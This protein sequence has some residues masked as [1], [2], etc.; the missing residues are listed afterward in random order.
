MP[1][2]GKFTRRTL[3]EDIRDILR[4]Y[5]CDAQIFK[6][7]IQNGED[8]GASKITFLYDENTYTEQNNFSIAGLKDYQ[9]PSLYAYN[10]AKF[11]EKDWEGISSLG[12]SCKEK[13][14]L[15]V[16]KFGLGFKS[17]FHLSDFPMV[18]SGT[19]FMFL[20]P[21]VCTL[22][23][24]V[25]EFDFQNNEDRLI[26]QNHSDFELFKRLFQIKENGVSGT[27]FRFPLRQK[28]SDLSEFCYNNG[29]LNE[30]IKSLKENGYLNLLFL[31]CVKHIELCRISKGSNE[32]VVEYSIALT[33]D[34]IKKYGNSKMQFIDKI[35]K[36]LQS[37]SYSE[38]T[39]DYEVNIIEKEIN[40]PEVNYCYFVSEYYSGASSD[41][42]N[43]QSLNLLPLVTVAYPKNDQY[44]D[45]VGGHIFCVLPLPMWQKGIT[46]LPV[47]VNGF[48]ALSEDRR[49]LKWPTDPKN[50]NKDQQVLWNNFLITKL[51]PHAYSNLM[52]YLTQMRLSSDIV[53]D[54]WPEKDDVDK[55]WQ[56]LLNPFFEKVSQLKCFYCS[57]CKEW[58]Y[59]S[60][61]YILR[62][63]L[64]SSEEQNLCIRGFFEMCSEK[65]SIVPNHVQSYF[66]SLKL[67]SKSL[68]QTTLKKNLNFYKSCKS[69]DMMHILEFILTDISDAEK[70][71]AIPLLPMHDGTLGSINYKSG[72]NSSIFIATDN[73]PLEIFPSHQNFF[74]QKLLKEN[75]TLMKIFQSVAKTGKFNITVVDSSQQALDVIKAYCEK[76]KFSFKKVIMNDFYHNWYKS[77]WAY[78]KKYRLSLTN[79]E[80]IPVVL[81]KQQM[82][83]SLNVLTQK[84]TNVI[85][86]SFEKSLLTPAMK[87]FLNKCH[88]PILYAND[89]DQI[90][91][92]ELCSNNFIM[93]P[94]NQG[95]LISLMNHHLQ[96]KIDVLNCISDAPIEIRKV[97]RAGMEKLLENL[98]LLSES[99]KTFVKKLKVFE[100]LHPPGEFVCLDQSS[101]IV[102]KRHFLPLMSC[103]GNFIDSTS[104]SCTI[105]NA[106][107]LT[108]LSFNDVVFFLTKYFQR[109]SL[110][111]QRHLNEFLLVCLEKFEP[112]IDAL[113]LLKNQI[114]IESDGKLLK[115]SSLFEKT[116]ELEKMFFGEISRFPDDRY[117]T[118][119]LKKLGLKLKS[120]L[121]S[122]DLA[123][124]ISFI[125]K[126]KFKEEDFSKLINKIKIILLAK[127]FSMSNYLHLKWIPIKQKCLGSYPLSLQWFG[128]G[129]CL[130]EPSNVYL[131]SHECLIG[132]VA[133]IIHPSLS[134]IYSKKFSNINPSLN[135]IMKHL[136]NIEINYNDEEK[137]LYKQNIQI[138]YN[139]LLRFN[140]DDVVDYFKKHQMK[141]WSGSYFIGVNKVLFK[142]MSLNYDVSP[143]YNQ[144]KTVIS[145]VIEKYILS[146]DSFPKNE[147]DVYLNVL[148]Q[149]KEKHDT[150]DKDTSF[151]LDLS[152]KLVKYIASNYSSLPKNSQVFVPIQSR[153]LCLNLLS[154]CYYKSSDTADSNT[155]YNLLHEL[156]SEDDAKMLN[157]RNLVSVIISPSTFSCFQSWGQQ[158]PLTTKLNRVLKLYND[159]FAI[160]KEF[161][162]NADDAGAKV[163]KFLYDKRQNKELKNNLIDSGMKHW[164]GP[165]LWIYNS[166]E[167]TE[168][169]FV[170]ITKLNAGTKEFDTSKVG[171]F[172]L[173][174]NSVYHL[175]DVPSILSG[176]TLVVFDPHTEYLGRAIHD[177]REPGIKMT[178]EG[179]SN[180]IQ[181]SN[182]FKVFHGIFDC[183]LD[184]DSEDVQTFKGTLFRI[185]LRSSETAPLSKISQ[186]VYSENEMK[187]LYQKIEER[188]KHLLLFTENVSEF[189]LFE[190]SDD[191]NKVL[192]ISTV[193][194][195]IE[196]IH[197]HGE[198]NEISVMKVCTHMLQNNLNFKNIDIQLKVLID[199]VVKNKT[200]RN[201]YLI[202][203]C[204]GGENSYAYAKKNKGQ[205]SCGS[206]AIEISDLQGNKF[207]ENADGDL[208]CFLPL[209]IK[210]GLPVHVNGFFTLSS[211]RKHLLITTHD[212]KSYG[213]KDWNNILA[214]D[215]S[216]AYINLLL[217]LKRLNSNY[218]L[219][220]WAKIIP[221]GVTYSARNIS[222][223][224]LTK[225]FGKKLVENQL[226]LFPT[227]I[228]N[229]WISWKHLRF[230]SNEIHSSIR[231]EV[232]AFMNWYYSMMKPRL[233]VVDTPE[234]VVNLLL[235]CGIS[236]ESNKITVK[237]FISLFLDCLGS[238]LLDFNLRNKITIYFI[239]NN[240]DCLYNYRCLPTKPNE[241]L[242]MSSECVA[243]DSKAASLFFLYDEVFVLDQF[244]PFLSKFKD[245][246]SYNL[247]WPMILLCARSISRMSDFEGI[248][249]RSKMLIKLMESTETNECPKYIKND[250]FKT[251][252]L[253]SYEKP[254]W[255]PFNIHYGECN[256]VEAPCNS[257]GKDCLYLASVTKPI[258]KFH[259]KKSLFNFLGLNKIPSFE[260]VKQQLID[261]NSKSNI[262][263][264]RLQTI[265]NDIYN[266]LHSHAT[267]SQ[268]KELNELC[269]VY[270]ENSYL[271]L[272]SLTFI[273]FPLDI[274]PYIFKLSKSISGNEVQKSLMIKLGVK[275]KPEL[276][277]YLN[278]L[279]RINEDYKFDS[280][281]DQLLKAINQFIIP[282]LLPYK[283]S[284]ISEKLYLPDTNGKLIT[285]TELYFKDVFWTPDQPGINYTHGDIPL[286]HCI[287]LGVK[288]ARHKHF[289]MMSKGI[290]FKQ[291]GQHEKLTVRLTKLLKGY[292]NSEDILN[293]LLQNADDAGATEVT[294]LLDTRTH[295]TEKVFS[296]EWRDLQGPALLI[297][298][299]A[300]FKKSD[301]EGI[302]N[303]G[304]G[305]KIKNALQTGKYGV[306]F[307]AVYQ[308]TD[309]PML[310]TPIA[311]GKDVLCVFDPNLK[312]VVGATE[313]YP[314]TMI[315]D[316]R[317]VIETYSDV[318]K[319]LLIDEFNSKGMTLFR[320]PLRNE[321]MAEV[322][323]ISKTVVNNDYISGLFSKFEK[324]SSIV[325]LFLKSVHKLTFRTIKDNNEK[326]TTFVAQHYDTKLKKISNFQKAEKDFA[327][328]LGNV[329]AIM[330][331]VERL[332]KFVC[333][334][335]LINNEFS[336]S[337][338]WNII[339]QVGFSSIDSVSPQIMELIENNELYLI[340]K[341]GIAIPIHKNCETCESFN[342]VNSMNKTTFIVDHGLVFCSLPLPIITKL[343]VFINGNFVLEYET[344]RCLSLSVPDSVDFKWN[345]TIIQHCVV[346]CYLE[347]IT[348]QAS[349]LSKYFEDL[350]KQNNKIKK[351]YNMFPKSDNNVHNNLLMNSFFQAISDH[352]LSV[353]LVLNE[354]IGEPKVVC[355][356]S[357]EF[358]IYET[359]E[360]DVHFSS[361]TRFCNDVFRFS[362]TKSP[363]KSPLL[364]MLQQLFIPCDLLPEHIKEGFV[365]IET[366]LKVC[367]PNII[368]KLL[369]E[370]AFKILPKSSKHWDVAK[371]R[372]REKKNVKMV[373]EYCLSKETK[374]CNNY[375]Q[376]KM[377]T[378]DGENNASTIELNGLPLCLCADGSVT[379]FSKQNPKFL[380]K[381]SCLFKEFANEFV[382]NELVCALNDYKGCDCFKE[383]SIIDFVKFLPE[384]LPKE[385]FFDIIIE[386]NLEKDKSILGKD[387]IWFKNAW[388]FLAEVENE[389]P[390]KWL[391][392]DVKPWSL[393]VVKSFVL[394]IEKSK[395]VL[396]LQNVHSSFEELSQILK[397][398][399]GVFESDYIEDKKSTSKANNWSELRSSEKIKEFLYSMDLAE[400]IFGNIEEPS[401]LVN[402]L[403]FSF[404]NGKWNKYSEKEANTVLK[405]FSSSNK[406]LE[407]FVIDSLKNLPLF[408][409]INNDF[410]SLKTDKFVLVTEDVL[411]DGL[412]DL[413][414]GITFLKY[415]DENIKS[416]YISLGSVCINRI[417]FYKLYV[418]PNFD[419]IDEC[420][421]DKH[422]DFIQSKF[423]NLFK[424]DKDHWI[425]L[426]KS[427]KFVKN[428][429]EERMFCSEL[430]DPTNPLF[431][432]IIQ[433]NEFPMPKHCDEWTSS[434]N[435]EWLLF[436][437]E[438]GLIYRISED[439]FILLA[440]KIEKLEDLKLFNDVSKE[441]VNHHFI[442]SHLFTKDFYDKIK[443]IK[444]LTS[445]KMNKVRENL[446]P[447]VNSTCNKICLN[448]SALYESRDLFWTKKTI[449]P[450]YLDQ[451]LTSNLKKFQQ[452]EPDVI[453]DHLKNVLSSNQLSRK[454]KTQKLIPSELVEP[455]LTIF[456]HIYSYFLSLESLKNIISKL[457]SM[458]I[459]LVS[460]NTCLDVPFKALLFEERSIPPYLCPVDVSSLGQYFKLFEEIGCHSKPSSVMYMQAL[461]N[462]KE[463]IN[464]SILHPNNL[465]I[466][467]SAMRHLS[468]MLQRDSLLPADSKLY[469][470]TYIF[471]NKEENSIHLT[472]SSNII[473]MSDL[474]YAERLK[475]FQE[476]ILFSDNNDKIQPGTSEVLMKHLP[477]DIRPKNIGDVL[478]EEIISEINP[479]TIP[480]GHISEDIKKRLKAPEFLIALQRLIKHD[481][482]SR[483]IDIDLNN[484]IETVTNIL[485]HFNVVVV[486]KIETKLRFLP[487]NTLIDKSNYDCNVFLWKSK[488][489]VT[490]Y[491]ASVLEKDDSD[492]IYTYLTTYLMDYLGLS[493]NEPT[494]TLLLFQMFHSP[495]Q[496]LSSILNGYKIYHDSSNISFLNH[497]QLP[498]PGDKVPL[499]FHPLLSNEY[500]E[501]EIDD[502]AALDVGG[503]D[504][505]EFIYVLIK[506]KPSGC[507]NNMNSEYEVQEKP[508][509]ILVKRRSF[510]LYGFNRNVNPGLRKR[511]DSLGVA[512]VSGTENI[513]EDLENLEEDLG[514]VEEI[515]QL[516]KA[517]LKNLASLSSEDKK[518]VIR[519]LYLRWHPDKNALKNKDKAT[520]I[521][522]FLQ[523]CINMSEEGMSN[524]F[525][526]WS[527]EASRDRNNFRNYFK[528]FFKSDFYNN[529]QRSR[530]WV[531]P[532]FQKKNPQPGEAKRWL[533]QAKV[534]LDCAEKEGCFE[535]KCFKSHQAAEKSLKS[536]QYLID[537]KSIKSCSLIENARGLDTQLQ[538]WASELECLVGSSSKLRYPDQWRY[539]RIPHESYNSDQADKSLEIARHIY[540]NV[541]RKLDEQ[542]A[543]C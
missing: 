236:V 384:V 241:K 135:L 433:K 122:N 59:P 439:I 2:S 394:P 8:A 447:S 76:N 446:C 495:L 131:D 400:K 197:R 254:D 174:F 24:E 526:R 235:E 36:Q 189:G 489:E 362:S 484:T 420:S 46:G 149:I 255:W 450:K 193:K 171:T 55:K 459:V 475:N 141:I 48:F 541:Q 382:H 409:S 389:K 128:T 190:I 304:E 108:Q 527:S 101:Y 94:T 359:K 366:Q 218:T 457:K 435:F 147:I 246:N 163:V 347:Y 191:V 13:E 492:K 28:K 229:Q 178:L 194:K 50:I 441:L 395:S 426:L 27:L 227:G 40:T 21:M 72:Y 365:Q 360:D 115:P 39:N 4:K 164:H 328:K 253:P 305:M 334:K 179:N 463:E 211:D 451:N 30:L 20:D 307:N 507:F 460:K 226:E 103:L 480:S 524:S 220:E 224:C 186:L 266:Y 327:N 511:T 204:I 430:Y 474:C 37:P 438:N 261:L 294:F 413:L 182:Q 16:G 540:E 225:S 152:I 123:Q 536:A 125:D 368:C 425:N 500:F 185:P 398:Y 217:Q 6:E 528:T 506:K 512:L 137:G 408:L 401:E 54:C 529:C 345:E 319:A 289:N 466:A 64:F 219:T 339:E 363:N 503:D 170:N 429:N 277:D 231:Q 183:H 117:N 267:S 97:I 448:G 213:T 203:S 332:N 535:W 343:P 230:L 95:F 156:F 200:E 378:T 285:S 499:E 481:S 530:S 364:L 488:G 41:F 315:E 505:R 497:G 312:Y 278:I 375:E 392:S 455:F 215:L 275:D 390:A 56:Q 195:N 287:A 15:K 92:F 487:K 23:S 534:D 29:Q 140:V 116:S 119:V 45:D 431:D 300:I 432:K 1:N 440:K 214:E 403:T 100:I 321:K 298:N 386:V 357:K 199:S 323:E 478:S 271:V 104:V 537:F 206:I 369:C 61:C 418:I 114:F 467:S 533:R 509:G 153:R 308:I 542:Q 207:V 517:E 303:L 333:V 490:L 337:Y 350:E 414:K 443:N 73:H 407:P 243:A 38:V 9:G 111:Q 494:L 98:S 309:C 417:E 361:T 383:F 515:C 282:E 410:L 301:L 297:C 228:N 449:L 252:F 160:A 326:S 324:H 107:N 473:A 192:T 344:R 233:Y 380:T 367:T 90:D 260:T 234:H 7:I 310:L 10:N 428:C 352:N 158:E 419:R 238:P 399:F 166:A 33:E 22:N 293:E 184:Y 514:D 437:K 415:I 313:Q 354:N 291:F 78:K 376:K 445:V 86:E 274:S 110:D 142:N 338:H 14:V 155:T 180:F 531:P 66:S 148:K 349:K 397:K 181:F 427:V 67:I 316:A 436:L 372:F 396:Q 296:D 120:D 539:P 493:S 136:K 306:G 35:K 249:K 404:N 462:L 118:S 442:I 281:A 412:G 346:P 331:L 248:V 196:V 75:K 112:S 105:M 355:V 99:T 144:V 470:P 96:S 411:F 288:P 150:T 151:D 379:H 424:N 519:R 198:K 351:F 521:F 93:K 240:I 320:L 257:F 52:K 221:F 42:N 216:T 452:Y 258:C 468:D 516:I 188:I 18:M 336:K 444:F 423:R 44:L 290:C 491:L 209:P 109:F 279:S 5:P 280:L 127:N 245:I 543:G 522:Q 295:G 167:F 113:N 172:G 330:N 498:L 71:C 374:K 223:Q 242:K 317:Q 58:L 453:I 161:V 239:N 525:S 387:F 124:S 513:D 256:K 91:I 464:E 187:L 486:P 322:S 80:G 302:Q 106:L 504:E 134:E 232:L 476:P 341:G 458:S 62:P 523:K 247:S 276:E 210:S 405:Q 472:L 358:L 3:V 74:N 391:H 102:D 49:D 202:S 79:F 145:D 268:L 263:C 88:V 70:L 465:K 89:L 483:S 77:L 270:S 348:Q 325:L 482:I 510:L 19:K 81:I 477:L 370:L 175:T 82:E 169:D 126:T 26:F 146:L 259:I 47:H 157:V 377:S 138:V 87:L 496:R 165:A 485:Q 133:Y 273:C 286:S 53:Y 176:N 381:H 63:D 201:V 85:V 84:D 314:G 479:I 416:L 51:L 456:K 272:P 269:I 264:E 421:K 284:I 143:Y 406:Y 237:A 508:D 335:H 129:K 31:K 318:K 212:E 139:N 32:K 205:N 65:V 11:T 222:M 501:F 283:D 356:S 168:Q 461:N 12:I 25:L 329:T 244:T 121:S 353:L 434:E 154:E 502:Y 340:P 471:D 311:D 162:Q 388:R 265:L 173:G 518:K 159:G 520:K 385:K 469:L 83:I 57:F 43:L 538:N 60:D 69:S 17:V 251:K 299:N 177:K 402:A 68:V 262:V 393:L 422:I 208:F 292:Q 34:C 532:S 132:S 454:S 342:E 373:L 371:T 250:L 130:V